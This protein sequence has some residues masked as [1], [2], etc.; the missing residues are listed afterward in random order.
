[1]G[2]VDQESLPRLNGP[3]GQSAEVLAMYRTLEPQFARMEMPLEQLE[4]T[5]RGSWRARLDT[6]ANLELGRGS[7]DD[8]D[9]RVQRFLKTLTQVTSRY[10][11]PLTAVESADLRH[12]NGYAIRLRGVSTLAADAP[13]K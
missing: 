8:V 7:A 13:K 9:V 5:G 6:G 1:M 11:R 4:L 3:E 2:E 12:E 10:A